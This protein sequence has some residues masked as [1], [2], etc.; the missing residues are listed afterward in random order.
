M[1]A[2]SIPGSLAAFPELTDE[3]IERLSAGGAKRRVSPGDLLFREGDAT[4]DLFI[5][6][7]GRVEIV[8]GYG[9]EE[10]VITSHGPRRFL[11]EMNLLTG[12]AVSLT[13]VV[14]EQGEVL[15][16]PAARLKNI[17][18]EDESLANIVLGAFWARRQIMVD[19]GT[20]IHVVGS[21]FSPASRRVREFLARNRLPYRWTDLDADSDGEAL[22]E[23]MGV[24]PGDTPV[25]ICGDLI[26]RNPSNAG[27][28]AAL[29]VGSNGKSPPGCDLV[30]VGGGPAGLAAAVY[31]S[32]EGLDTLLVDAVALGGQAAT[33]SRIENYLG[34]PTGISG[35]ELAQRAEL[36]ARKFGARL[37]VSAEAVA[38]GQQGDHYR[39]ALSD[40]R[41]LNGTALILATGAS[42]RR[43][44]VKGLD[45]YDGVGVY[46][47]A[48]QAEARLCSGGAV[49]VVGGGNSAGQAA[50]FLSKHATGCRLLVR[51]SDLNASMSRY[52]VDELE[53][54]PDVEVLTS[55]EVVDAH[56]TGELEAVVV[57]DRTSGQAFELKTK[58]LFVFIGAEPHTAWLGDQLA[59]DS[60][61]FLR[62]GADLT[63]NDL[64]LYEARTPYFLE[65]SMPGVFAVGDVRSG[66]IKRVASA[67]GEGAMAVSLAHQYLAG[68]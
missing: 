3:Q 19:L 58:A 11:G 17:V 39:V 59:S 67:A 24:S 60:H 18:A 31:G 27:L 6:V 10:R 34:F 12:S 50:M 21:R 20:G 33:S 46:Y 26:L 47:A 30:I 48:T 61:G 32:S 64:A 55:C 44:P 49:V 15:Q 40:G 37:V 63:S 28:A 7:S 4:Y 54:N 65:T 57:R 1:T 38:L 42:Y 2:P 9:I 41:E 62:T 8:Q 66:S 53:R 43:L 29:N 22:L 45:R 52:L 68:R 23:G 36:Q 13:G 14:R 25:V 35:G 56:G 5:I 16:V 51:G